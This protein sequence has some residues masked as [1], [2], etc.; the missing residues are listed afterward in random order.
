M[1]FSSQNWQRF[2]NRSYSLT[3]QSSINCFKKKRQLFVEAPPAI[4]HRGIGNYCVCENMCVLE[5]PR[6]F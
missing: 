4:S 1:E 6:L 2:W 5:I 3:T